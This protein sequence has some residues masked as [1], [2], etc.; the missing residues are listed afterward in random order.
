LSHCFPL[1]FPPNSRS[2]LLLYAYNP[3][4]PQHDAARHGWENAMNGD[5]LIGLPFE[6][7]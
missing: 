7:D 4:T 2:N 3:H 6:V 5:E 1:R